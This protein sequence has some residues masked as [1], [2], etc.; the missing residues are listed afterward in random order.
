MSASHD[1]SRQTIRNC[2]SR[3]N[4]LALPSCVGKRGERG[5][6][7]EARGLFINA[8]ALQNLGL[9]NQKDFSSLLLSHRG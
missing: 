8:T 7:D 4:V 3:M 9:S 5:E 6:Y 2:I 1:A